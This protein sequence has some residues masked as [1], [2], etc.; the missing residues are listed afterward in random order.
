MHEGL[1]LLRLANMD[2]RQMGAVLALCA[3]GQGTGGTVRSI[4]ANLESS[5][6]NGST[7][8]RDTLAS[9]EQADTALKDLADADTHDRLHGG[10]GGYREPGREHLRHTR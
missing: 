6:A 8:A 2:A 3:R 10:R 7:L 4:L 5:A 9:Y 1:E